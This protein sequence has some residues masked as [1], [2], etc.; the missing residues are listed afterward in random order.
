MADA[1]DIGANSALDQV[2]AGSLDA[3]LRLRIFSPAEIRKVRA[4]SNGLEARQREGEKNKERKKKKEK[5]RI[6]RD[7]K[8]REARASRPNTNVRASA[9]APARSRGLS[10]W[11]GAALTVLWAALEPACLPA[12]D[13]IRTQSSPRGTQGRARRAVENHAVHPPRSARYVV[14]ACS[15]ATTPP[16]STLHNTTSSP[17]SS[18]QTVDRRLAQVYV[19]HAATPPSLWAK[20]ESSGLGA[21]D[22]HCM[23]LYDV[24]RTCTRVWMTACLATPAAKSVAASDPFFSPIPHRRMRGAGSCRSAGPVWLLLGWLCRPCRLCG[25]LGRSLLIHRHVWW[26]GSAVRHQ[27]LDH[28][29][30]QKSTVSVRYMG[31]WTNKRAACVGNKFAGLG[32]A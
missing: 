10:T 11:H 4:T 8:I 19:V 17:W 13:R 7:W 24:R 14:R 16:S 21:H 31:P 26:P 30:K 25:G 29:S 23:Q 12:A 32:Q 5:R 2:L 22:I 6:G 15:C 18:L 9:C 1:S 3:L 20:Y 27:H 28:G